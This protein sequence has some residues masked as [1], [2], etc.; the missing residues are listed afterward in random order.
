[1]AK[2]KTKKAA[3]KKT[4]KAGAAKKTASKK[5]AAKQS[6]ARK[7]STS[8]KTTK[9]PAAKKKVAASKKTTAKKTTRKTNKRTTRKKVGANVVIRGAATGPMG[10]AVLPE[11][12]PSEAK[13]RKVKTGMTR[14][15]LDYF[16]KLLLQRRAEILGDVE[17]LQGDV[18]NRS[19]GN[20]SNLPFHMADVGSDNYEHEFTLGL[21]ESER[22]M[23]RDIDDALMRMEKGYYGVCIETGQPINRDRLEAKPWA[24]YTIEVAREKERLGLM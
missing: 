9:K 19:S 23:L 13:L 6:T 4:T 3:S 12:P 20:L 14:K 8:K 17:S 18:N 24:R 15:D 21:L 22:K 2:K 1:M 5:R 11:E 16:R 10:S 7:K